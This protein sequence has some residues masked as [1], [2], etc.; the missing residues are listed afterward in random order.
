[1][2]Q[3]SRVYFNWYREINTN[4]GALSQA[5]TPIIPPVLSRYAADF[6]ARYG[7]H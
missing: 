6:A 1:M 5:G 4:G 3:I 2:F 7:E